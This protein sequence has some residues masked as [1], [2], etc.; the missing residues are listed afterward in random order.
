MD[1]VAIVDALD[2][3][4]IL[5]KNRVMNNWYSIYCPLHNSG[6]ERRSSAGILITEEFKNGQKYPQGFFHCFACGKAMGLSE[7][8]TEILSDKGIHKSGLEFLKENLPGLFDSDY[9]L[10]FESLVPI[11]LL[12]SIQNKFALNM[13]P[14]RQSS[15]VSYVSEDTLKQ[16]RFTVPYLYERGLTDE[17]IEK[18]D[19]G[20]DMNFIPEG[21]KKPVPCITFPVRDKEGRCIHVLRRSIQGKHFYLPQGVDKPVYGLYELPKGCKSIDIVEGVFD[22]FTCVKNGRPAVA[23]L[24]TGSVSQIETIKRLGFH[25]VRIGT[26]PDEAGEKGYHRIYKALHRNCM[27]WRYVIPSGKDINDLNSEEFLSLNLM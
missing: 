24:G 1:I 25:D 21:K 27:V 14:T 10:S 4:G 22:M 11:E 26:D 9:D 13:L 17:L 3:L 5:R 2:N 8:V 20:V 18:Y 23:L 6:N 15:P 19:V 7:L 12:S 16:Y